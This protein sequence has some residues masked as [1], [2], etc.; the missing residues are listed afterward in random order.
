MYI[1]YA[2]PLLHLKMCKAFADLKNFDW[3]KFDILLKLDRCMGRG[4]YGAILR[5]ITFLL[6]FAK[7]SQIF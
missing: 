2:Q 7:V 1:V 6:Y 4:I 5:Y 3:S